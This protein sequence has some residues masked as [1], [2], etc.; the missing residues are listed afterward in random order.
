MLETC[1]E[2]ISWWKSVSSMSGMICSVCW[3]NL[4]KYLEIR[5]NY[6]GQMPI[7]SLMIDS[8]SNFV[9][10]LTNHSLMNL[11]LAEEYSYTGKSSKL[12]SYCCHFSMPKVADML[13]EWQV[14]FI[15]K[16]TLVCCSYQHL[17]IC[18]HIDKIVDGM[19]RCIVLCVQVFGTCILPGNL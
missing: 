15:R 17:W 14:S 4:T 5:F 16:L 6:C 2:N 18:L 12:L 11:S 7:A 9:H 19:L 10:W 13:I 3:A 1:W 8:C